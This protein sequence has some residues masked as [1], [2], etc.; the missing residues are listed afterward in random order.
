MNGL[1]TGYLCQQS[2]MESARAGLKPGGSGDTTP[3]VKS[4][5]SSYTGLHPKRSAETALPNTPEGLVPGKCLIP[6]I[7]GSK[8]PERVV[9]E[10]PADLRLWLPGAAD[11]GD[12]FWLAVDWSRGVRGTL[13][14]REVPTNYA[15]R[16]VTES[17]EGGG[18][19]WITQCCS[20]TLQHERAWIVLSELHLE[21]R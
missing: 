12:M 15:R 6:P 16:L 17:G 19:C 20:C 10:H 7:L 2:G 9:P 3:C 4:L 13:G 8:L 21:T 11:V 5:R 18:C 1:K 14:R